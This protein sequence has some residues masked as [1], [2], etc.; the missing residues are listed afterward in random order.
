M[1]RDHARMRLDIWADED[2]TDLTSSGQWLY[3]RLLTHSGLS[4]CGVVE[5]RPKRIAQSARDLK[6]LD[7]EMF[8]VELEDRNF[9]VIDRDTEECLVRSFVKHDG[10]MDKWNLAAAVART[11]TA[12]SSKALRGA[13]VHELKAL[14]EVGRDRGYKVTTTSPLYRWHANP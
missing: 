6:A 10:L 13:I 11:F 5:W 3:E 12:V 8:A 1:P 7:V 4:Y 2:W 14:R 9:L